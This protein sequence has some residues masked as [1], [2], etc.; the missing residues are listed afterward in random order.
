MLY[1]R[2][3][4]THEAERNPV[5]VIPGIL[6]SRLRDTASGKSVWGSF[7]GGFA[8]PR[9]PEGIRLIALPLAYH[10]EL[11]Q[12]QTTVKPDGVLGKVQVS[13]AG[14]PVELNAYHGMLQA[15]GV[16]GYRDE[17]IGMSGAVDYGSGHF[18]CFQFPY[19]WR[20]D[21]SYNARLLDDFIKEKKR[22]VE[23]E[24]KKRYGVDRDI[25]FSIVAHSMGGLLARYYLRY[26]R[27]M[28]PDNGS[29]PAI[30]W[31][32]TKYV[33]KVVLVGTPNAGSIQALHDLVYG[34]DLGPVVPTYEPA[35][36]GTMPAVYQLLPR[37]RHRA[38]RFKPGAASLAADIFDPTFW[39]AREWGLFHPSQDEI[40]KVLLPEQESRAARLEAAR[41]HLWKALTRARQFHSAMDS[42]TQLP[43][44]V[45]LSIFI[46]DALGTFSQ[47]EIDMNSGALKLTK[48]VG[49]DGTVT[50]SSALLDERQGVEWTPKLRTPIDWSHVTFLFTDHLGLTSDPAF[51]DNILFSLLEYPAN[52]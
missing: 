8:D 18:T 45:E 4:Q 28:L 21:I 37:T 27:E 3:A 25:K 38:Y 36:L 34:K 33:N 14:L 11:N 48:K 31:A 24:L 43:E 16:G 22:Y 2:A 9:T 46:G 51:V 50:R 15:L 26:G 7:Y 52:N 35:I 39:E 44:G 47:A 41:A 12:V 23:T 10:D 5:I 42:P 32:G 1:D 6:G 19:D 29:V 20:R 17:E 40:L 13:L 30:T 49:G